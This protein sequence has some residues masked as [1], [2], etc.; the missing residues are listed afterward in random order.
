MSVRNS[1]LTDSPT[2]VTHDADGCY[3]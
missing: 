1:Q 2:F 3:H